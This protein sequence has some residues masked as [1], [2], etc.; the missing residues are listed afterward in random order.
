MRLVVF[1]RMVAVDFVNH[2]LAVFRSGF[3]HAVVYGSVII[4]RSRSCVCGCL[5]P[6]DYPA[7]SWLGN[8][9]VPDQRVRVPI[10]QR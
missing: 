6:D 5:F 10:S 8:E 4:S 1:F 7:G 3:S 9:D 2:F